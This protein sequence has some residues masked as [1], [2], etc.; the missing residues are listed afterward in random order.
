MTSDQFNLAWTL[1][2]AW[3]ARE[4]SH[5][6][7]T[8][9]WGA[10][11][12]STR[13]VFAFCDRLRDTIP[14]DTEWSNGVLTF[15]R[16]TFIDFVQGHAAGD[17]DAVQIERVLYDG[18]GLYR[19]LSTIYDSI[20]GWSG[21]TFD[22]HPFASTALGK[23]TAKSFGV[24]LDVPQRPSTIVVN[25][26]GVVGHVITTATPAELLQALT[27]KQSDRV[28]SPDD[29]H[30]HRALIGMAPEKRFGVV[31]AIQ[32]E[33][34]RAATAVALREVVAAESTSIVLSERTPQISETTE[35]PNVSVLPSHSATSVDYRTR[36]DVDALRNDPSSANEVLLL[37]II[38]I[39][40]R[41]RKG[42]AREI[43][44]RRIFEDFAP[45]RRV[46]REALLHLV[47]SRWVT[48]NSDSLD[49]L[50]D[51]WS[52]DGIA[53]HA[54]VACPHHYAVFDTLDEA[55][56]IASLFDETV[57]WLL[58]HI[59]SID[60]EDLPLLVSALGLTYE[61]N[62]LLWRIADG[63]L[64]RLRTSPLFEYV[65]A[66]LAAR[67]DLQRVIDYVE[68]AGEH[69]TSPAAWASIAYEAARGS[70]SGLLVRAIEESGSVGINH[71]SPRARRAGDDCRGIQDPRSSTAGYIAKHV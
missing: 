6:V 25:G 27:A 31:R 19:R 18:W 5:R 4:N 40:Q 41:L 67:G 57:E 3:L 42:P 21:A 47:R 52:R 11:E 8:R 29:D 48:R 69:A 61:D 43:L 66:T 23:R 17:L 20:T 28:V 16:R 60:D 7:A 34:H 65:V 46:F 58:A 59:D 50:R 13:V 24:N 62:N 64:P 9:E 56:P 51:Y 15:T 38:V 71:R 37:Q 14:E 10:A 68:R 53:A 1:W 70:E 55:F 44:V 36:E 49:R 12:N 30:A 63:I 26:Y 32:E 2:L 33:R 45:D 35:I 54:V 39:L 22:L